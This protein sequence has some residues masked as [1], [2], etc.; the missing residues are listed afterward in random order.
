MS[1]YD[2]YVRRLA[3]EEIEARAYAWRDFFGQRE[4]WVVDM[5][6]ILEVALP[7]L[8]LPAFTVRV[9]EAE[10]MPD[11]EAVTFHSVPAIDFRKD[12]YDRLHNGGERER[13]TAAHE[14]GH[15]LL[16]TGEARPR[17]VEPIRSNTIAASQSSERQADAFASSFLMPEFIVREFATP[18]ELSSGCRV[19]LSAANHRMRELGLWPKGR[20]PP[21]EYYEFLKK[22]K[23][24]QNREK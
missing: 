6:Q 1:G 19:S 5:L 15:L 11:A 4:A 17:A 24:L 2:K 3:R 13:F 8:L 12:V 7:R 23:E 18:T 22:M 20:T 9:R 21:P 14:L 16:H 10:E